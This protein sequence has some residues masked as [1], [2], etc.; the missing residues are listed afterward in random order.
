[1]LDTFHNKVFDH[2]PGEF[3]TRFVMRWILTQEIISSR[4]LLVNSQ[5]HNQNDLS[6]L[7]TDL[8]TSFFNQKKKKSST[9]PFSPVD[10]WLSEMKHWDETS[11]A[12]FKNIFWCYFMAKS[13]PTL[14]TPWTVACLAP[15][16]MRFP[17]QEYW[18]ELPF[19]SPGDLLDPGIKP[20][21]P[22]LAG[23]FFTLE[24]PGKPNISKHV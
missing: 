17:R 22:A 5:K 1:M 3:P 15:L 11:Q 23:G 19:P 20:T 24:S 7:I 8:N 10:H 18:S 16:S 2:R 12:C 4:D 14:V 6:N 9:C 21:S 13:S